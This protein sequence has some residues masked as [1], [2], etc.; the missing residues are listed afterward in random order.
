MGD[1]IAKSIRKKMLYLVMLFAG[2]LIIGI[3]IIFKYGRSEPDEK[4]IRIQ[5]N[6]FISDVQNSGGVVDD[7]TTLP[8]VVY[9]VFDEN[10]VV[11]ASDNPLYTEGDRVNLETVGGKNRYMAPMQIEGSIQGMFLFETV[12]NHNNRLTRGALAVL[13]VS[14][15][16]I[17]FF[18]FEMLSLNK[19]LRDDVWKPVREL[20]KSTK[21]ISEG[22]YDEEIIYDYL[23][24]IG[25]LCHDFNQMRDEL[26]AGKELERKWRNKE[27][28]LY[29]SLSHDL[30]TPLAVLRGYIEEIRYSVVTDPAEIEHVLD[31]SLRKIEILNKLVSD[32][33]EHSKAELNQLSVQRTEVYAGD[34]FGGI[35]SEYADELLA[36]GIELKYNLP[37]NMLICLDTNRINQVMQNLISNAVKYGGKNVTIEIDFYVKDDRFIVSVKDDGAGIAASDLP[38]IFELFYRGDKSRTQDIP[39]S[40]LGLHICRYIIHC[41]GG[42]IECDSIL[43]KGTQ[44]QFYIPI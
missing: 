15:V 17:A 25:S 32:I 8:D 37:E 1:V 40:G 23:G 36:Q 22:N 14:I 12:D 13:F 7:N 24:E 44:I 34:F 38:H 26:K 39:G 19:K 35:L 5:V 20:H 3:L 11:L 43:G 6:T 30:N 10:G 18:I 41:H 2:V 16:I 42:E 28:T 27:Q 31:M 9:T 33:L 4:D 29:A 21:K